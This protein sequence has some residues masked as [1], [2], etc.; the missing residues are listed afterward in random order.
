MCLTV[1]WHKILSLC[2][3]LYKICTVAEFSG[4][5]KLFGKEVDRERGRGGVFTRRKRERM[6]FLHT[7][8]VKGIKEKSFQ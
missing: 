8:K 5:K 1:S 6:E 7:K 3:L 2:C 4:N